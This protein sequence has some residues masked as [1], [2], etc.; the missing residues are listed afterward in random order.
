MS[1]L[2]TLFMLSSLLFG[3]AILACG[4]DEHGDSESS[5]EG[6]IESDS[7]SP[8]DII[9][10]ALLKRKDVDSGVI[11]MLQTVSGSGT[12]IRT[13]SE[14]IFTPDRWYLRT[15][16]LGN[17]TELLL[18]D[19]SGCVKEPG[20]EWRAQKGLTRATPAAGGGALRDLSGVPDDKLTR[21]PDV[22]GFDGRGAYV[23]RGQ[24]DGPAIDTVNEGLAVRRPDLKSTVTSGSM[25]LVFEKATFAVRVI[26]MSFDFELNGA[27]VNQVVEMNLRSINEDPTFPAGLPS[28]CS[29]S[30]L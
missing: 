26:R 8:R 21:L 14:T 3:L 5:P 9:N 10:H 13:E 12:T 2:R 4:T 30:I 28:S 15:T 16:V 17:T 7:I 1:G 6:Y 23:V 25:E 29:D 20:K 22:E 19:K 11:T 27:P 18:F 24:M